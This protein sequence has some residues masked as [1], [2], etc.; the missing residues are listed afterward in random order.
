MWFNDAFELLPR[1]FWFLRVLF[2]RDGDRTNLTLQRPAGAP[3]TS[4]IQASTKIVVVI[5]ISVN[6]ANLWIRR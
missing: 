5:I 3:M 1:I 6:C 2:L 4:I